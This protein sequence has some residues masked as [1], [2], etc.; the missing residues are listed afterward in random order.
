MADAA[1]WEHKPYIGD[2]YDSQPA[3]S[4]LLIVGF[5]HHDE[6]NPKEE[7]H[8]DLTE[9]VV[10][11]HAMK[12][13]IRF[14]DAI[15]EYFGEQ[16]TAFWSRVAF[17]N[18]L[19]TRVENNRYSG[20]TLEQRAAVPGRVVSLIEQLKPDRIFVFTTK[21]W[22][23]WPDYTGKLKDGTLFVDGVGEADCGTYTHPDGEAIAFGFR[24]PQ[25]AKTSDMRAM[26]EG[27]LAYQV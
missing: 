23:L 27:A 6:N 16:R 22:R 11:D 3:G 14:F 20:G 2:A 24:H 19:G 26:V 18:T 9:R 15:A 4:K 12:G 5:S 13:G 8:P 21:G 7:D 10:R 1:D 17:A 25:W